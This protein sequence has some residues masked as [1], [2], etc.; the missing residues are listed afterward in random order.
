M[1]VILNHS[2]VYILYVMKLKTQ[3]IR[4]NLRISILHVN[5]YTMKKSKELIKKYNF[6][7]FQQNLI[8][9]VTR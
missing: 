1:A 4:H 5:L 6:E 2:F 8:L 3:H 9:P 7:P